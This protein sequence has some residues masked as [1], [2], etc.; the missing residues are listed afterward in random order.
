[1]NEN[2]GKLR[3]IGEAHKEEKMILPD[4]S[5]FSMDG[6][7]TRLN[8]NVIVLATSGGGKT[9]STVIPNILS[10]V[11]SYVISDPKGTLYRRYSQHLSNCGYRIV[12]IDLI[13][14]ERSDCWNPFETINTSD[15]ILR[16]A[17]QL[18]YSDKFGN[19]RGD[20][21]WD[22]A[23]ELLLT[24]LIGYLVETKDRKAEIPTI[25][26][27]IKLTRLIDAEEMYD[28][29]TCEFDTEMETHNRIYKALYDDESWAY[30]QW[31]KFKTTPT[32]TMDT[33]MVTMHVLFNMFDTREMRHLLQKDDVHPA[34]IGQEPTAVFVEISDTDRSKDIAANIFYGQVMH[35]LCDYADSLPEN[36]LPVPVRFILDDFGTN[37]RIEGF[38][39]MIS[40]IRSRGISAM[41]VIQSLAQ[42]KSGYGESAQTI[43]DNC[44][45][46]LYMGGRDETT[47]KLISRVSGRPFLKIMEMPTGMHWKIQ[48]GRPAE[49]CE[50]VDLSR[51]DLGF[52]RRRPVRDKKQETSDK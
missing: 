52:L 45:T 22:R 36:R 42:L 11:G 19:F 24:A 3:T 39:N 7:K 48:R 47:V 14:P 40:N 17:H 49:Y 25:D 4:G 20:P 31:Q 16:F 34:T 41:V 9:R 35:E 46:L 2:T 12:H 29:H 30:S 6:I 21:F 1:M 5:L 8:N 28:S 10:A 50:T 13:H 43:V 15:E 26:D 32:K 51:Y 44:D 38:E 33:I 18:V 37:V 27:L 23:S